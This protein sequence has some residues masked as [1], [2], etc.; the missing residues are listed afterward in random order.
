MISRVKKLKPNHIPHINND[1]AVNS[2]KHQTQAKKHSRT[3]P[4]KFLAGDDGAE[5]ESLPSPTKNIVDNDVAVREMIRMFHQSTP[6]EVPKPAEPV[7]P[8]GKGKFKNKK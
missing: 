3:C 4:W 2:R 6:P 5:C 8:N 7:K 1:S